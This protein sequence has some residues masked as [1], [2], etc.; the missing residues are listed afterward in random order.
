MNGSNNQNNRRQA[1]P[2]VDRT[3]FRVIPSPQLGSEVTHSEHVT[4]LGLEDRGDTISR[5]IPACAGC[6]AVMRKEE[7]LGAVCRI[8]RNLLCPTCAALKCV[9][10]GYSTCRIHTADTQKGPV[11]AS[12]G[13]FAVLK[14]LWF[15]R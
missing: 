7:E 9:L 8:C 12:H 3:T 4:R 5:T 15:G 1:P 10:C 6:G 2:Q 13:F 11:C 14:F